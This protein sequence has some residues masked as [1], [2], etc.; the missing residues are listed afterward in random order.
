MINFP[1]AQKFIHGLTVVMAMGSVSPAAAQ[2][3][4]DTILEV[5]KLRPEFSVAM[6]AAFPQGDFT[7]DVNTGLDGY[8]RFSFP[9][10]SENGLSLLATGGGTD[11]TSENQGAI[12]DTTGALTSASQSLDYRSAFV[13]LGL[14]WTGSWQQM[15][16]R[17]RIGVSAGAHWVETHSTVT[18]A[19]AKIDSLDQ[20]TSVT[21]PGIRLQLG[22]DWVLRNNLALTFEFKLDHVFKVAQYEVSD[23]VDPAGVVEKSVSY[24]SFLAGIVFPL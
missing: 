7:R 19:G 14:Q 22:S 5:D 6:G 8:V 9:I 18:V 21:R 16:L 23:G 4:R 13:H 3:I 2:E 1:R 12:L 20:T 10:K 11:F 15:S 17:P 24:V